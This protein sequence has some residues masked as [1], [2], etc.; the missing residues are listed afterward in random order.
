M[1]ELENL[2]LDSVESFF[3][4]GE[5]NGS[6]IG[7]GSSDQ[8]IEPGEEEQEDEFRHSTPK[9]PLVHDDEIAEEY[10]DKDTPGTRGEAG[11]GQGEGDE[12]ANPTGAGSL[13]KGFGGINTQP[14]HGLVEEGPGPD[15]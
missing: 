3:D 13:D 10:A 9:A 2:S 14:S 12:S 15:S 1:V 11:P 5:G 8:G 4:G 6:S 7:T